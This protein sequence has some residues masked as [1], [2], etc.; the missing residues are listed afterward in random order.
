MKK[1]NKIKKA[2]KSLFNKFFAFE[3]NIDITNEVAVLHRRNVVIK[4]ITLLSN[5]FYSLVLFIVALNSQNK[6][7]WL[8][9]AIFV[10][11]TLFLNSAIK[12]L[13]YTDR[14]D[15]GKQQ[16]AMYGM[17]IYSFISVILFYARFFDNE[18]LETATYILIYYALIVISLYQ[19]KTL[20]LWS[21]FGFFS[22]ITII[23]FTWTYKITD[24]FS[25]MDVVTFFK[26]FVKHPS[27]GDLLLRSS[28]FVLFFV[29]VY[30]I[31]SIGN[32]MQ[33]QR[34]FELIKRKEI[35][36][37]YKNIVSDLLNVVL[38]AKG[39]L[40]DLQH[41]TLVNKMSNR[42]GVLCGLNEEELNQL[43]EYALSHLKVSEVEDI[44]KDSN[45]EDVDFDDLKNKT[46]LA[47]MVAKRLQLSQ[48]SEDIARAHIDSAVNPDFISK[49]RSIQPEDIPQIILLTE[50]YIIMRAPRHYKRAYPNDIV[51][52]LFKGD[53]QSYFKPKILERFLTFE[54]E[55]G[56]IFEDNY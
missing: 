9:P 5:T 16:I 15:K 38:T 55:F 54:N 18:Y 46:K 12:K 24:E 34:I 17:A 11:F 31:V 7:D 53:F 33:E 14:H 51:L 19:S 45:N 29:V 40:L 43:E 23:H 50:L 44:I 42:L 21:S 35:Q 25:N 20:I 10:P 48:K 41:V 8:F 26:N 32:Y 52:N 39:S 27:F 49:M 4:N 1:K 13:I 30:A 47:T 28:V 6:A 22:G 37:D 2:T 3:N 36:D 56:Q